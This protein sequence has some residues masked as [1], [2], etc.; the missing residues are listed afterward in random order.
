MQAYGADFAAVYNRVWTGF[1]RTWAPVLHEFIGEVEE[2]KLLD[3][4]CGT[5]QLCGYFLGR[6]WEVTGLDLSPAMLR[7]ASDNNRRHLDSGTFRVV[8]ADAVAFDVATVVAG[9][10]FSVVISLFDAI[11]HLPDQAALKSCF[12]RVHAALAPRG[13]FIFDINTELGLKGW[14][15]LDVQD[16]DGLFLV[17]RGMYVAEE[18]K[19]WLEITGFVDRGGGRFERFREL[20]WNRAWPV[21]TVM[22]LL[23]D[24]GFIEVS[25]HSASRG[26]PTTEEPELENRVFIVGRK[27]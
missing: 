1:S 5:G 27:G 21:R 18:H 22:G 24:A 11:N 13:I 8:A 4:C 14:S 25:V 23:R 9:G 10:T 26:L 6:G 15:T 16:D 7:H 3:L 20:V 12:G 17:K 19:A 2:R